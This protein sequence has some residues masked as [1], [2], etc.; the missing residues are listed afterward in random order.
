MANQQTQQRQPTPRLWR[1][2]ADK[3]EQL[4]L[5]DPTRSRK[6][7]KLTALLL[8][9][10]GVLAG[11]V[12]W[13]S[14][15]PS[16]YYVPL[17]I[18]EYRSA[19]VTPI[20]GA[21]ADRDALKLGNY[22]QRGSSDAFGSQE[23]HLLMRELLALRDRSAGESVV[24]YLCGR[25]GINEDNSPYI[26]PADT[27][28]SD[29]R[30]RIA[31]SDV[32]D[33]LV[34]CP[35]RHKLLIL[36]IQHG[37]IG[38]RLG[39]LDVGLGEAIVQAINTSIAK[40]PEDRGLWV[41]VSCSPG[42][43][44][45]TSHVR[46]R[47]VFG[48]YVEQGLQGWAE[49][50]NPAGS[51][52]N[53][54]VSVLELAQFVRMRVD[55][56]SRMNSTTRQTPALYGRGP[57]FDLVTM[58]RGQPLPHNPIPDLAKYPN[59]LSDGWKARDA[60][61]KSRRYQA[62]PRTY[63]KLEALLTSVEATWC[64]GGL[65]DQQKQDE[66]QTR[67]QLLLKQLNQS[68]SAIPFPSVDRSLALARRRGQTAEPVIVE[69]LRKAMAGLTVQ[70]LPADPKM[71]ALQPPPLLS[72]QPSVTK[73]VAAFL[74]Q[75]K[76]S[77]A[78]SIA[79]AMLQSFTDL[80]RPRA[81]EVVFLHELTRAYRA[82]GRTVE[83]IILEQLAELAERLPQRDWPINAVRTMVQL[84]EQRTAVETDPE[85]YPWLWP[86]MSSAYSLAEE[87]YSLL[88]SNRYASLDDAQLT[89]QQAS[90]EYEILS[91]WATAISNGLNIRDEAAVFVPGYLPYLVSNPR[92]LPRWQT[93]TAAQTELSQLLQQPSTQKLVETTDRI[94]QLSQ[95]VNA[96]MT[97]LL[98]PF[99]PAMLAT[100][101]ARAAR[102]DAGPNVIDEIDS[103]LSVPI[104]GWED[105]LKLF[106]ARIQLALR[107][108]QATEQIDQREDS[109]GRISQPLPPI[110]TDQLQREQSQ[111]GLVLVS[112]EMDLLMM[113]GLVDLTRPI[114]QLLAEQ[115]PSWGKI[116]ASLR[117]LQTVA[118]PA[119]LSARKEQLPALDRAASYLDPTQAYVSLDS[120]DQEPRVRLRQ[121]HARQLW[122]HLAE[123]TRDE[124]RNAL[125]G[126]DAALILGELARSYQDVGV[127]RSDGFVNIQPPTGTIRLTPDDSVARRRFRIEYLGNVQGKPTV[128]VRLPDHQWLQV[129]VDDSQLP[130]ADPA[131]PAQ[132]G[133]LDLT[134]TLLPEAQRDPNLAIPAGFLL[135]LILGERV[136]RQRVP[137]ELVRSSDRLQ[138]RYANTAD[139]NSAM[140]L[141][142][143]LE[144]RPLPMPQPIYF[145]LYNPAAKAQTA[146]VRLRADKALL[147]GGEVKV[148]VPPGATVPIRFTPAPPLV[149][150]N[151]KDTPAKAP[152]QLEPMTPL[153]RGLSVELLD[154]DNPSLTLL[155]QDLP[156]RVADPRSYVE[157]SN[158]SF[159]PMRLP[160]Q[161]SNRLALI[162][163]AVQANLLPAP[164]VEL[165]LPPDRIPGL[166]GRKG[167]TFRGQVVP[168]KALTL[169]A[170]G[171][172][173]DPAADE[174]GTIYLKVDES[175][176]AMRYRVS[177][178]RSGDPT[179]PTA[180]DSP[181]VRLRA[182]PGLVAGPGQSF[183]VEVDNPPEGANLRVQME[184]P[185]V[186]GQP[187]IVEF[188]RD[189]PT[190][191][192]EYRAV[193][194]RP[195][196]SIL[197]QVK[198]NDWTVPLDIRQI[199]GPR[200]LRAV[201]HWNDNGTPRTLEATQP[202]LLDDSPPS[203]VA[204][205]NPPK[206]AQ[207]AS[208]LTLQATAKDIESGISEM[209][210]VLGKPDVDGKLPADALTAVGQLQ[211]PGVWIGTLDLPADRKGTSEMTL[212]ATNGV[213]L[214][215]V[216]TI[217]L[218]VVDMLP[219]IP[220]KVSGVVLEGGRAQ[221]N[222]TVELRDAKGSKA[223]QTSK[224]NDDG[225]YSFAAV[226]PGEYRLFCQKTPSLRKADVPITVV[227]GK[228][229]VVELMLLDQ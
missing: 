102:D 127:A 55:R 61:R 134:I 143:A 191:R 113:A 27:D 22:F 45:L 104:L 57:D 163:Q 16:P 155:T 172:Q 85:L 150:P 18:T 184:R 53:D 160:N 129:K 153:S 33:A 91:S 74:E 180:D 214:S 40:I 122:G 126:S 132:V 90:R 139:P 98:Q 228:D 154:A 219:P 93:L 199:V 67:L 170:D 41:L 148:S 117:E 66:I 225:R 36:D 133:Q 100:L 13:I 182:A 157:V 224:T 115:P 207:K 71:L 220:A 169:S 30:T 217:T 216:K 193:A 167:G 146:L 130:A 106:E 194:I 37:L 79:L 87:G 86:Q 141:P 229:I 12:S 101:L 28:P 96:A 147:P 136:Y 9:V 105:R 165:V 200:L 140:P 120:R 162:V 208:T 58:R 206:L 183:Q 149:V 103:L 166:L 123:R 188:R 119:Q 158:I 195:D 46:G 215:S 43:T 65:G 223:L 94:R 226:P 189:F 48:H 75:F 137:V 47:T 15:V 135:E 11:L 209:R 152:M 78:R 179:T 20:P 177:F 128:R 197:L 192:E 222:L 121:D 73:A 201:M 178:V 34:R 176:R 35:A 69:A 51:V 63:R 144:V 26:L 203:D 211:S 112:G 198:I 24:V 175:P 62:A 6:R 59:W 56:W 227:N 88:L 64:A 99:T 186:N 205:L 109:T 31:L 72:N 25:G 77:S 7:L 171:L 138:L 89:L 17:W 81:I 111:R 8:L 164:V 110:A 54:R 196:G 92:L 38:Q 82:S 181:A 2:Q 213:G 185:T 114:R 159:T 1:Q 23:Q 190:A 161:P 39:L 10:L 116:S 42:Q 202:I 210:F 70:T 4:R 32:L 118:V 125:A 52:R 29:T 83:D 124:Q 97:D 156:V 21:L 218:E 84:Y 168:G 49:Q 221:P 107:L 204:F 19:A 44:S 5:G 187:G 142:A 95:T 80:Q 108:E 3:G 60:A 173:L 174:H 212:V 151:A 68:E 50:Y 145:S 131:I 76:T 14:P